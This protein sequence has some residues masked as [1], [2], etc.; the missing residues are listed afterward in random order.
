M[1]GWWV[2]IGGLSNGVIG[3]GHGVT[4]DLVDIAKESVEFALE[5]SGIGARE[6]EEL[7]ATGD[8]ESTVARM[9]AAVVEALTW[10]AQALSAHVG[11]DEIR[12]IAIAATFEVIAE[13]CGALPDAIR[14]AAL[15]TGA[16]EWADFNGKTD[17][18]VD[19]AI[20]EAALELGLDLRPGRS[21][22]VIDEAGDIL[23]KI[24]EI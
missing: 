8:L 5:Q 18:E 10:G 7:S 1:L 3:K 9:V 19:A 12:R 14:L 16:A 24:I 6:L 21:Q 4:F 11:R 2:A 20:R 22:A 17:E 13:Q 23:A 15:I